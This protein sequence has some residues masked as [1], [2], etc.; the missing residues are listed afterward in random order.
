M[1]WFGKRICLDFPSWFWGRRRLWLGWLWRRGRLFWRRWRFRL[2]RGEP[3]WWRGRFGGDGRFDPGYR[4][5]RL[6]RLNRFGYRFRYGRGW[7]D[8]GS[9]FRGLS[10]RWRRGGGR[11]DGFRGGSPLGGFHRYLGRRQQHD[12]EARRLGMAECPPIGRYPEQQGEMQTGGQQQRQQQPAGTLGVVHDSAHSL[13]NRWSSAPQA[14]FNGNHQIAADI[15]PELGIQLPRAGWA[16]DVDF[17]QKVANH[18]QT[19]E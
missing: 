15:Q 12:F 2:G 10:D 14:P 16:G 3:F 18:V 7:L 9:E 17:G 6:S 13:P 1:R 8:G 4:R 5:G 11:R 19:N